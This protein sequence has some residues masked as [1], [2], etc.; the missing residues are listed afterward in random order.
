M[1]SLMREIGGTTFGGD[2]LT[3]YEI[4]ERGN[5]RDVHT[6]LI[7]PLSKRFQREAIFDVDG[8]LRVNSENHAIKLLVIF[9]WQILQFFIDISRV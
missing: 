8:I 3:I 7:K 2:L 9:C 5:V 1:N 4:V 6:E